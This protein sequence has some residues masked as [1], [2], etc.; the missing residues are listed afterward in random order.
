MSD[1]D[2][3]PHATLS[4]WNCRSRLWRR[5]RRRLCSPFPALPVKENP[6][7]CSTNQVA[8]ACHPP[9][10]SEVW[11]QQASLQRLLVCL[12]HPR[13][14]PHIVL[15]TMA[16]ET[17]WHAT[18]PA[19]KQIV[20]N[21]SKEKLLQFYATLG[22]VLNAGVL[23]IDVRR[24]D[25]EGGTIRGSLNL[26][27]QSFYLNRAALYRLCIGDGVTGMHRVIF[28]C[29]KHQSENFLATFG[30]FVMHAASN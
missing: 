1:H 3:S 15:L 4:Q 16:E 11:H 13:I 9:L 19:P 26:P 18:F 17:P 27:A 12:Q 6:E 14:R 30:V 25:Y 28:Y 10:R 2:A 7:S 24:T 5:L 22:D 8:R 20:P 21:F 23:L 29:G